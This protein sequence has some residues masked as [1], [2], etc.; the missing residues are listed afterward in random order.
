MSIAVRI[1]YC[2]GEEKYIPLLSD[3]H[4]KDYWKSV[5][6]QYKLEW[7]KLVWLAGISLVPDHITDIQQILDE[8]HLLKKVLESNKDVEDTRFDF[9]LKRTEY[10]IELLKLIDASDRCFKSVYLG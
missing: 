5:A 3:R 7:V 9:V 6:E 4:H 10:I 2:D 8:F 1:R